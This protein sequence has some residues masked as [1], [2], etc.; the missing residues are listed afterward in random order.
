MPCYVIKNPSH[1]VDEAILCDPCDGPQGY[2]DRK[3][4]VP[5]AVKIT[6]TTLTI[7]DEPRQRRIISCVGHG[8]G[9]VTYLVDGSSAGL[10]NRQ[11]RARVAEAH[12]VFKQLIACLKPLKDDS[13][14]PGLITL[15]VEELN[16]W[17][18]KERKRTAPATHDDA[19]ALIG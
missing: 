3:T 4:D 19:S 16:S 18:R 9:S 13:E 6:E 5:I 17:F 2:P 14:C 1:R 10:I 11:R 12:A 15:A 7:D 8:D